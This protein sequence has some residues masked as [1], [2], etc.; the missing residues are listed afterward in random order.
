MN[1]N[2]VLHFEKIGRFDKTFDVEI[3]FYIKP[4]LEALVEEYDFL[5][6]QVRGCMRSSPDF[7][8]SKDG[9]KIGVF[10]GFYCVGEAWFKE[11]GK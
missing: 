4:T 8:I 9:K 3:P 11:D 7:N 2:K 6:G 10:A 5:A 1:V